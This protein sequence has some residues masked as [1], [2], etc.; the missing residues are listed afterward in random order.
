MKISLLRVLS[1]IL[2][3]II[4]SANLS[5]AATLSKIGAGEGEVGIVAWARSVLSS[6]TRQ[7]K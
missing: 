1:I 2:G 5:F 6:K 4:F 7:W 3:S